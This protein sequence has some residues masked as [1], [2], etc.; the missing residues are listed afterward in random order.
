MSTAGAATLAVVRE[1]ADDDAEVITKS[2]TGTSTKPAA[3]RWTDILA[4][5]VP[6]GMIGS[7]SFLVGL[8]VA[9]I[10]E[11]TAAEPEPD[12]Y[13]GFR[14]GV[15]AAFTICTLLYSYAAY[16]TRRS[17]AVRDQRRK[18]P[19]ELAASTFAFAA[20]GLSTPGSWVIAS[21]DGTFYR[22]VLPTAIGLG[23]VLVLGIFSE[24]I[25]TKLPAA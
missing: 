20:W 5:L 13:I 11:P 21:V 8:M 14:V 12:Q 19:W 1:T 3:A 22:V 16:V 2:D 6:T 24:A 23:A 15:W 9:L 10:D 18:F 25:K 4:K 17:T 7:Y